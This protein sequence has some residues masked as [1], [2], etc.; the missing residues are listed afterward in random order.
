LFPGSAE[1]REWAAK[2][3]A[4]SRLGRRCKLSRVSPLLLMLALQAAPHDID[5]SWRGV[6]GCAQRGFQDSLEAYLVGGTRQRAVQ[7]TVEVQRSGERWAVRLELVTDGVRSARELS[8]D[9]CAEVSSAAAFITAVLVDP[10]TLGRAE[11]EAGATP[12]VPEPAAPVRVPPVAVEPAGVGVEV[13]VSP[14]AR[15]DEVAVRPVAAPPPS[16]PASRSLAGFVRIA[17]GFEALGAPGI[18]AQ[19]GGAG[20]LLGRRWRV[21]LTG[22]Y[23]APSTQSSAVDPQA[24]ARVGLWTVGTR[25]CGVLRPAMLEVVL[26]GGI[27]AGQVLGEG[28]GFAGKRRDRFAWLAGTLGPA[29]AWAPRRWFALWLGVDLAVPVLGGEFAAEGLGTLYKIAPVSIRAGLGLEARFF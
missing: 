20:G 1:I 5:V 13:A 25:G 11:L 18:G 23:R 26:C 14:A 19:V 22:M 7:V 21:E 16:R 24:G 29:L 27:E 17:G 28:V 3:F 8:G 12:L 9:S 4:G 15:P 6:E 10:G 2:F